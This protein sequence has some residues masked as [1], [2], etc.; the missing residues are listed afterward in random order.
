MGIQLSRY[1]LVDLAVQTEVRGEAFY[2]Q[3]AEA[4]SEAEEKELFGFLADE[5][6]RHKK[7]FESLT[8]GVFSV[9]VDDATWDEAAGYIAATVDSAFF[10]KEGAIRK[11]ALAES[12]NGMLRQAIG[13]E[14][15]TILYFYTLRDLVRD[16]SKSVIDKI[17]TEER[18][19]VKRLSQMLADRRGAGLA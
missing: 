12:V 16:Q 10:G 8:P 7:V 18:S 13:F 3:A 11:I 15:Q 5:E 2:R 14:Q 17:L 6:V 19:H 4:V 9:E 1:D